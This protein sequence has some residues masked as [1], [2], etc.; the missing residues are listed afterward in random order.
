MQEARFVDAATLDWL[1]KRYINHV[2]KPEGKR[3]IGASSVPL[4][5]DY[6]L[7]TYIKCFFHHYKQVAGM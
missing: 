5:D 7:Y 2:A 1:H 6:I 3:G 4:Y